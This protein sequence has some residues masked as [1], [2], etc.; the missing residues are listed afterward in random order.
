M[1]TFETFVEPVLQRLTGTG[2]GEKKRVKAT[3]GARIHS[4]KGRHELMPVR[5][6]DSSEGVIAY[7]VHGGSGAIRTLLDLDGYIRIGEEVEIVEEGEGVEVELR[8]GRMHLP[9]V[10]P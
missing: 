5:L 1:I 3:V 6:E 9:P 4:A 8:V 10:P 2:P 7:Q